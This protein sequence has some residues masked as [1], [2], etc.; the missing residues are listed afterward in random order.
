MQRAVYEAE[1][2]AYKVNGNKSLTKEYH[3]NENVI[4]FNTQ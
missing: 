3:T 4:K 2:W 1:K